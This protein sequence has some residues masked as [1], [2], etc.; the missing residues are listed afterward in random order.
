LE[1][2]LQRLVAHQPVRDRN[3][4]SPRQAA[5]CQRTGGEPMRSAYPGRLESL[6]PYAPRVIRRS[7]VFQ[8]GEHGQYP[9]VVAA[10]LLKSELSEDARDVLLDRADG[11]HERMRDPCV[12]AALGHQRQHLALARRE[13]RQ[14]A[15]VLTL[16]DELRYHV[17]VQCRP[18]TRH[19]LD[20]V[21]EVADV[22]DA[23]LEQV[24][25][26]AAALSEQLG[27][28]GRLYVLRNH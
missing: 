13:L 15:V 14:R 26:A 27:G 25:N 18:A 17:W 3:Q 19:T 11:E 4:A 2:G 22:H 5:T 7:L 12:R 1:L 9:G 21:D 8:V 24:A 16:G 23:V 20:R 10:G 6:A 28:V